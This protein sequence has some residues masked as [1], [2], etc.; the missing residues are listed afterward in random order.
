[1]NVALPILL[2]LLGHLVPVSP[3]SNT[4]QGAVF[5]RV[6]TIFTGL[7]YGHIVMRY[8]LTSISWRTRQ[9][10]EVNAHFQNVIAPKTAGVHDRYFLKWSKMWTDRLVRGTADK[11]KEALLVTT[12]KKIVLNTTNIEAAKRM[13]EQTRSRPKRQFGEIIGPAII[14]GTLG[15]I[16]GS[17]VTHFSESGVNDVLEN[18]QGVLVSNVRDNLVR[19]NQEEHD[20]DNLKK[21]MDY[22]FRDQGRAQADARRTTY[23]IAHLQTVMTIQHASQTLREAMNTIESARIGEF[24]PSMVDHEGLVTAIQ[25]L[26]S[27]SVR[28][29]YE[30]SVETSVDL[31]HLPCTMVIRNGLINLIIHVP[32]Y[33]TSLNLDLFRYI[34]HPTQRMDH[35]LYASLDMEG[36]AT[37]IAI[38]R[39][40]T[41]YRE[42][43]DAELEDCYKQSKR[44]FC[45]NLALYSKQRPHCLW[46][47]YLNIPIE[48]KNYCRV[49]LSQ[50]EVR[51]VRIDQNTWSLTDTGSEE[52]ST[53]CGNDVPKRESL[54]GTQTVTINK[55]CR[56][57][58][59]HVTID[60]PSYE[61]EIV[62][63]GLVINDAI[64]FESWLKPTERE[65]FTA[66]AK[67]I[68]QRVGQKIPWQQVQS[69][70][71]FDQKIARAQIT[72]PT[73]SFGNLTNW[74]SHTLAS[75][76]TVILL[77]LILFGI[78]KCVIPLCRRIR[79]QYHER[80]AN[81]QIN[82]RQST[83]DIPMR[84]RSPYFEVN[85]PPRHHNP[86]LPSCDEEVPMQID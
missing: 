11:V 4:T 73:W 49:S 52:I 64:S 55:G 16:A 20:I 70:T 27:K 38:N 84:P 41:K 8:N 12:G 14:G 18:K 86:L 10:E 40:E 63:E 60:H 15:T 30:P 47:L 78:I 21:A 17:V 85:E 61:P 66:T 46:A 35:D 13:W 59:N 58:T 22:L 74:F 37:F 76:G 79:Y 36:Q 28:K 68:L 31:T 1:M 5:S 7:A 44:Y 80:K 26:R 56:A 32:L 54:T 48:I 57:T 82:R 53:S 9:M 43:T 39:D 6:G 23:G 81:R 2:A 50:M 75:V 34:D 25:N 65:N 29:G 33:R 51:A 24:H 83:N 69:V 72:L 42:F 62:L 67:N 77:G 45:P 71:E 19:I 3:Q